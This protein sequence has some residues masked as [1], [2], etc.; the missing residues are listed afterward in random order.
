M[1]AADVADAGVASRRPTRV[2]LVEQYFY[3]E[4]W[5][6][7]EIPRDIAIGLTAAGVP[8]EV[9]CGSEQYAPMPIADASAD[10]AAHGVSI[11]RLPRFLPGPVHRM[12][13]LRI[14]LLCLCAVPVLLTR[15]GA[16]LFVT[17]TNPPLIVPTVAMVAALRRVPFAV[18]TMDVYPEVLF[19]SGL[20]RAEAPGGR[21]LA[22]LFAW[23]YRR[24]ARVVVLGPFMRG[25]LLAKGVRAE[26]IVTIANWATGDLRSERG[27]DNPLRARWGLTGRFVV[28]YSG[29][30]GVGHEFET[31]LQGVARASVAH[32]A[33][34]VV[35]IGAGSRLAEVR[36]QVTTL[37]LEGLV[38]FEDFVPSQELPRTMGIADLALVTLREGFEGIIVPSKLYGYMARGIP[39]LYVGPSSDISQTI[40]I[41]DCGACCLPGQVEA[42]AQLLS[43]A[44]ESRELLRRW[45]ENGSSYYTAHLSRERAVSAYLALTRDAIARC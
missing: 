2:V 41:A 7:A 40:E 8:V 11:V 39:T 14:L 21:T 45:S 25:R 33:L 23:A 17:Q 20:T 44:I 28:L 1:P 5:G 38:K 16:A 32:P 6:G 3:P 36:E 15:R 34:T 29:N 9:V 12:R 18:I 43:R 24:A 26:R 22:R 37:G 42:V 10:P 35:F 4:G 13:A 27:E 31:F 19:A 30:I